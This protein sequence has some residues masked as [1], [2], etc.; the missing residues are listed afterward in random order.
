M[1]WTCDGA[2][3]KSH[4]EVSMYECLKYHSTSDGFEGYAKRKI[5]LTSPKS[6]A[7]GNIVQHIKKYFRKQLVLSADERS[8]YSDQGTRNASRKAAERPGRRCFAFF[9]YQIFCE[10]FGV[11]SDLFL[12]KKW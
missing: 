12:E 11:I 8:K 6:T 1:A 5:K 10:L 3:R 9:E 7:V 2:V 4:A